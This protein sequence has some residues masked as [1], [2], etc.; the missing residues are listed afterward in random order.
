M[1]QGSGVKLATEHFQSNAQMLLRGL[2][3][4]EK[5]LCSLWMPLAQVTLTCE[6]LTV[7][8]S[9]TKGSMLLVQGFY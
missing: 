8:S 7:L 6:W 9:R 1:G 3:K 5:Q 2:G 4:Q